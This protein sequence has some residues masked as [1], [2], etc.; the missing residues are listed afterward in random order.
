M[1]FDEI[2]RQNVAAMGE[3]FGK[4]YTVLFHELTALHLYWKE[5]LELFGTNDKRI[6]R[7]N[8]AAPGFFRM[9]Q[10]QQFETNMLH[11]ARLT[12]SPRSV[13]KDNLTVMNLPNLVTDPTLKQELMALVED[14]KKKTEFCREWRNRRFAHHD[15]L[16][17][18]QDGK[19]APLPAA[20]KEKFGAALAALG[21]VLNAIERHYHK[22]GCCFDAI[23]AHAGAA[24]LLFT[25]GFGVKAREE[26]EGKIASG[27]FDELGAPESI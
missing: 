21:N 7:L 23:A 19:A 8:H 3:A 24:T 5:F 18:V 17:A 9:L 22:G 1:N 26:M 27:K 4:Q 10:E 6:D 13:G 14:A 2:E 11:M 15:L 20:S 12:D 16:L 25:L